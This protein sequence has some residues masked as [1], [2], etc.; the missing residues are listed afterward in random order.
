MTEAAVAAEQ[1]ARPTGPRTR[2][3]RVRSGVFGWVERQLGISPAG[4]AVVAL[5]IAGWLGARAFGGRGL[6]LLVYMGVVTLG[7]SVVG[8]RR[9]R[10]VEAV[11]S[12]LP[13]RVREGQVIEVEL[14]MTSS[15]RLGI[16][17]VEE[18]VN[19]PFGQP[20]RVSVESL[21][22]GR[23][24][25]HRYTLRPQLRGVCRVGPLV[26]VWTDPLGLAQSEQVLLPAAEIIVHPTTERVF[27]RP[28]TRQ[29][30]DPPIRPPKTSPWPTGFEFYGMRDYTPGDDLRRVVWRA[31]ART[32]RVL[33]R[34]SEQGVTDR[35]EI[36]LDSDTEWHRRA[37][38]SDTFETAVRIA[39]SVG[40]AHLKTGFSVGLQSCEGSLQPNLRGPSARLALLDSL[41]R[42]ELGSAPLHDAIERL[43]HSKGHAHHVI[44]TPH[45]D[46]RAAARAAM[47]VSAGGSV[48]VCHI[49]WEEAD[50]RSVHRATEIGAQVLQVKPGAPL[51][52]V[53][54][55][56]LGAGIR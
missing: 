47:L 6:Y 15:K 14:N 21:S 30:E 44:V 5:A 53:F 27:D 37:Q 49:N 45:F 38:P 31:V 8:V 7:L 28:L 20:V 10:L 34:E 36:V 4:V 26:A 52:G 33:V 43:L 54:A 32:G 3:P 56:A 35:V 2:P 29:L 11:R 42:V 17:T 1:A 18:R 40:A 39:A 41:A 9:R 24:W 12:E 16:F 55:H 13:L 51:A 19:A 23:P 50:P 46:D 22:P 25:A 48:L